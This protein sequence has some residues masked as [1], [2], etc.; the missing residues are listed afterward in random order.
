MTRPLS[1]LSFVLLA[2]SSSTTGDQPAPTDSGTTEDTQADTAP[3]DPLTVV[4]DKGPVKGSASG[5]GAAFFNIP[6][7]S[8]ERFAAPVAHAPWTETRDA[9][10]RGPA[11]SQD[12]DAVT[13]TKPPQS[14]DCLALN[15]WTPS[16][17]GKAPVMLFIHGGSFNS[18]S[19]NLALYDGGNL[20]KRGV[21]VVTINYRLGAFGFLA[22]P[23]LTKA[24]VTG[25]Q[26]LLDQIAAMQ[27]VQAN[28]AKFGGDP[29]NV[30][31]FGESAGAISVCVHMVSPK[32]KGLFHKAIAESGTCAL[33]ST[34]LTNTTAAED[35]AEE[36]GARMAKELGC[37]TDSIACLRKKTVDEILAKSTGGGV[38]SSELSFGPNIDGSVIPAPPMQL[39]ATKPSN[40][41]PYMTG[42]NGDEA[43]LFNNALMI[44]TVTDYENLVRAINPLLADELLKIYPA[45]AFPTPKDAYN[46]LIGDALFVC[47]ARWS[48]QL[49]AARKPAF[50]YHF[51]HVTDFGKMY[52]LGSFHASELWFV[53][54]NF[55]LPIPGNA[56]EKAISDAMG[57]YWT[58]FAKT[59]DPN[60]DSAVTWP[61]YTVAEDKHL[62][63]TTPIAA[64]TGLA[65]ARCDALQK[66]S[67]G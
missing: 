29:G 6:Y 12:K 58:R 64:A 55:A 60:G 53:F 35:S 51:T 42:A 56:E 62:V 57:G 25:N 38:G 61:K 23:E 44:N 39:L 31:I 48:T 13:M 14:E 41:V 9:S 54:G 32:S 28:I 34:R 67:G 65:K 11:C 20:Q 37:E 7:A 30:T 66:L 24:G 50:L 2:C 59:G 5:S 27:W 21:V 22:H 10:M 4:T 1:L 18:G 46:A 33:V 36:R 49:V 8:A 26:G 19:G 52:K 45:S 63:I 40:D 3:S 17:Q 47:P 16:T 15:I 43:T